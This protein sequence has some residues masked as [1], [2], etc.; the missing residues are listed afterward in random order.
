MFLHPATFHYINQLDAN[1]DQVPSFKNVAQYEIMCLFKR[2]EQLDAQFKYRDPLAP[3]AREQK[4]AQEEVQ[5]LQ[6]KRREQSEG[7]QVDQA[8]RPSKQ[9]RLD[10]SAKLFEKMNRADRELE[11]RSA[12]NANVVSIETEVRDYW[13]ALTNENQFKVN[14]REQDGDGN[15]NFMDPFKW[16]AQNRHRWPWL[17]RIAMAILSAPASEVDC[18]RLFS[19]T[20]RIM[21]RL[22]C[23]MSTNVLSNTSLAHQRATRELQQREKVMKHYAEERKEVGSQ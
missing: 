20:R 1:R 12:L 22:R 8:T 15:W 6:E 4:K 3:S 2:I 21:T 16:W 19:L 9:R 13:I 10:A 7:A 11:A 5:R 17:Y 14:M 23:S 18:E